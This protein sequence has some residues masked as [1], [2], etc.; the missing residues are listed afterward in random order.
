MLN[1]LG[2]C[3]RLSA[4]FARSCDHPGFITIF[5]FALILPGS[6]LCCCLVPSIS[7]QQSF[8]PIKHTN[9]LSNRNMNWF[10]YMLNIPDESP[11]S[12]HLLSLRRHKGIYKIA[13]VRLY[14]RSI[15]AFK[16][17]LINHYLIFPPGGIFS[18]ADFLKNF[19]KRL[20]CQGKGL[21]AAQFFF[22]F[23]S[24]RYS[25]LLQTGKSDKIKQMR[26][27]GQ[28]TVEPVFKQFF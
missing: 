21:K 7:V 16:G 9:I 26:F 6:I 15:C 20:M 11:K 18:R 1:I 14:I 3:K 4:L 25:L 19:H 12:W 23:A 13:C 8:Q 27:D 28:I 17:A 10:L 24:D 5:L 2:K 22:A